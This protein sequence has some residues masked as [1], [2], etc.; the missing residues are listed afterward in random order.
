VLR[1]FAISVDQRRSRLRLAREGA[2]TI[3]LTGAGDGPRAALSTAPPASGRPNVASRLADY[4]GTYGD[5]TLSIVDGK[6]M[7]QRP[8]GRQLEL[9][10]TGTDAFTIVGIPEAKIEFGRGASGRV[11]EIRVL[12][13]QGQWERARRQEG[14]KR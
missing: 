4:A 12:T 2:K 8:N 9:S 5:R 14:A 1:N 7:I 10:S 13:Q 3:S 6:L 11:E